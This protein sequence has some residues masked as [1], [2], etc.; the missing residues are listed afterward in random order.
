MRLMGRVSSRNNHNHDG[1]DF[2]QIHSERQ[3]IILIKY[4]G[5]QIRAPIISSYFL[6]MIVLQ[7]GDFLF[8]GIV[9]P[10]G[11]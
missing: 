3:N 1:Y 7:S 9:H 6:F 11:T 8:Q 4:G 10:P 2:L 5:F